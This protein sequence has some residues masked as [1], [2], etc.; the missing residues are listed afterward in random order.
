MLLFK[1]GCEYMLKKFKQKWLEFINRIAEQNKRE[2]GSGSID[3]CE[4]KDANK[5]SR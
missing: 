1:I 5:P 4:L 2:Y 3:C